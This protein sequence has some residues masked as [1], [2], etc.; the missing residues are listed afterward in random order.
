MIS[1]E[2]ENGLAWLWAIFGWYIVLLGIVFGLGM[3]VVIVRHFRGK[4]TDYWP[5]TAGALIGMG[6]L[7]VCFVLLGRLVAQGRA[8]R[9]RSCAEFVPSQGTAPED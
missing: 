3:P 6:L 8:L 9:G 7:F 4:K 2:L 1:A 5:D